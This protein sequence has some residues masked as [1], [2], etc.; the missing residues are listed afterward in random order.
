MDTAQIAVTITGLLL[1]AG[2]GWFFF[3]ERKRTAAEL[4]GGTQ[5]VRVRVKGG[6]S[7][8]TLVV[9]RGRPVRI[10]FDRQ[11]T[12]SCSDTVVFGDFGIRRP[13]PAFRTTA[14]EFT[15]EKTGE[16]PFTCGMSMLRGTLIVEDGEGRR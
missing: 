11:E 10:E 12:A 4:V 3:G 2:V 8:D 7:P 14:V 9:Q 13:L 15:P 5:V 6:Y 1:M 16:Y